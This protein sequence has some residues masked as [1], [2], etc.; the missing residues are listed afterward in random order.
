MSVEKIVKFTED[1]ELLLKL[2]RK[3]SISISVL[4][5][6]VEHH[7]LEERQGILNKI[8]KELKSKEKSSS[9]EKIN[10]LKADL[11]LVELELVR[12]HELKF[13]VK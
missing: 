8:H 3:S 10:K 13:L 11:D 9:F 1:E 7:F 6:L 12:I 5:N 2:L 4:I